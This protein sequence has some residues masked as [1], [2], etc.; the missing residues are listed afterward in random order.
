M[1]LRCSALESA[2]GSNQSQGVSNRLIKINHN[3]RQSARRSIV[4]AIR[5]KTENQDK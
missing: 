2:E 1:G 3:S 5:M 4:F